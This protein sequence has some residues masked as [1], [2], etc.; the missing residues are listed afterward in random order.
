MDDKEISDLSRYFVLAIYRDEGSLL[1]EEYE[2]L[3]DI[4]KRN[5]AA[6]KVDD[7]L[8]NYYIGKISYEEYIKIH[9][10]YINMIYGSIIPQRE[11]E[12]LF[13]KKE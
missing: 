4:L 2:E 12:L 5:N 7:A 3:N 6:K 11:K 9:N 1:L 8:Y 10:Y 13:R